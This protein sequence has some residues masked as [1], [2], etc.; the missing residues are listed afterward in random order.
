MNTYYSFKLGGFSCTAISDGGL[1]YPVESFFKDVGLDHATSTLQD[2]NLPTTHIYTP[3]TLLY[4]ETGQHKVLIDTGI[5][6]SAIAARKM[7]PTIDNSTLACGTV[8]ENMQ[9]AGIDQ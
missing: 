7:F 6:Q 3:Y 9:I 8:L 1:N 4:I 2:Q 5:G